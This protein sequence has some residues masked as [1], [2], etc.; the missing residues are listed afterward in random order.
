MFNQVAAVR[1]FCFDSGMSHLKKVDHITYACEQGTIERWAWFHIEVEGGT[2]INRIDDVRPDD[3]DSSMKIWCI[4]YGDFGVALIEGIDRAKKSQVTKFAEAHGDHACQHVAYDTHDLDAFVD[5]LQRMGGTPRGQ[6][7]VRNDGFGVLK[8]MFARVRRRRRRRRLF[9]STAS[10]RA[11]RIRTRWRSRSPR[12]PA[13]GS[14]TRSKMRSP[15]TTSRRSST[16]RSPPTRRFRAETAQGHVNRFE[17]GPLRVTGPRRFVSSSAVVGVDAE[18]H[19]YILST[20]N[21]IGVGVDPLACTIRRTTTAPR[22]PVQIDMPQPARGSMPL[23][24]ERRDG[25]DASELRVDGGE[26]T[27]V[28]PQRRGLVRVGAAHRRQQV[29][30][31]QQ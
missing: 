31:P 19:V 14:T 28:R 11:S 4:D 9:R 16:S 3:P 5:H 2:L 26:V 1:A 20:K 8:Q 27:F 24:G 18:R 29:P 22:L 7:L 15:P 21:L 30:R 25:G 10:A 12:R 23:A 13:R 6:V 17:R